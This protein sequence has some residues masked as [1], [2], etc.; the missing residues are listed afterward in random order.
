MKIKDVANI[1]KCEI[2]VNN[3]KAMEE[4]V[5]FVGAADMMSDILA[6]AKPKTL[7]LTSHV[8]PQIIRTGIVTDLV[9][10][11]IVMDKDVPEE[12]INLA[13][14]NNFLLLRTKY[15]MF[16]ACGIIYELIN[17]KCEKNIKNKKD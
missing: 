8:S 6:F 12:T 7:I 4:D 16:E 13:K 1:L 5:V 15:Y 11:I 2:L 10:V 17:I 14:E 9:G 3:D